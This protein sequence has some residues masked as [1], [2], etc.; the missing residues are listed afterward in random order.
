MRN[1]RIAILGLHQRTAVF[2]ADRE[3]GEFRPAD[4]NAPMSR[5]L[6]ADAIAYFQS[7]DHL[8]KNGGYGLEVPELGPGL[9]ASPPGDLVLSTRSLSAADKHSP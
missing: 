4:G 9:A 1:G 8:V 7:A 2:D 3:S 5:E 6:V